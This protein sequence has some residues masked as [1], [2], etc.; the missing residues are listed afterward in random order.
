MSKSKASAPNKQYDSSSSEDSVSEDHI[1]IKPIFYMFPKED[2]FQHTKTTDIIKQSQES[3]IS[4][5]EEENITEKSL[6]QEKQDD[7]TNLTHK[8]ILTKLDLIAKFHKNAE[9]KLMQQRL[10]WHTI[11]EF[12]F[13]KLFFLNK[14]QRLK[15]KY[16]NL[17][18]IE[19]RIRKEIGKIGQREL[20]EEPKKED[21]LFT[22]FDKIQYNPPVSSWYTYNFL[23]ENSSKLIAPKEKNSFLCQIVSMFTNYE[24]KSVNKIK[25]KNIK[26]KD[27]TPQTSLYNA[28]NIN[29]NNINSN[30]HVNNS[31]QTFTETKMKLLEKQK[32]RDR[33]TKDLEKIIHYKDH[34][35][36]DNDNTFADTVTKGLSKFSKTQGF[37]PKQN[38]SYNK[39]ELIPKGAKKLINKFLKRYNITNEHLVGIVEE[40]INN[41]QTDDKSYEIELRNN[42]LF[43]N[44]FLEQRRFLLDMNYL[45]KMIEENNN[46]PKFELKA[47]LD[48]AF[49]QIDKAID[50]VNGKI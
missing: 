16:I 1:P 48:E 42:K 28:N 33:A 11:Y 17:K 4:Q 45:K 10:G 27:N 6:S 20:E 38:K 30:T 21:N 24:N 37:K 22:M 12:F 15:G 23:S 26:E 47:E 34:F 44:S 39:K 8:N 25:I 35:N 5:K 19:L 7:F 41:V 9:A 32:Q 2:E 3:N 50:Y 29:N 14:E 49:N 31:L 13:E 46:E 36:D 43:L 18:E 40:E